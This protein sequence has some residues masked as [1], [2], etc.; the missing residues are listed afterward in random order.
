[1]YKHAKMRYFKKVYNSLR[2]HF[3]NK[4]TYDFKI[5]LSG[6]TFLIET[7]YNWYIF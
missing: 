7:D 2:S 6:Y 4:L 5:W 3:W 1:M